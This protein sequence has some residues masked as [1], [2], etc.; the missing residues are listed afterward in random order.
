MEINTS[1]LRV[2]QVLRFTSSAYIFIPDQIFTVVQHCISLFS[3]FIHGHFDGNHREVLHF[4]QTRQTQLFLKFT[5]MLVL[6]PRKHWQKAW[7]C[8]TLHLFICRI[9]ACNK[10]VVVQNNNK[11]KLKKIQPNMFFLKQVNPSPVCSF[12]PPSACQTSDQPLTPS[13]FVC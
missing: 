2:D 10:C 4:K 1:K 9:F 12:P 5:Q 8:C 13:S 6:L 7:H 11:K 3:L